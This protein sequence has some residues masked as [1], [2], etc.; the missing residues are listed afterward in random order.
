MEL[1][2]K[3]WNEIVKFKEKVSSSHNIEKYERFTSY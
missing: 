3:G 2:G 1:K